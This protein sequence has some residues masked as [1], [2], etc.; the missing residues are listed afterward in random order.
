MAAIA[1]ATTTSFAHDV[2]ERSRTTPV[3]VDFWAPWCGPCH[4]LSP[5]LERAA[6]RYEGEVAVVKVNVDEEPQLAT[7]YRVQ[8]I[9]AVKGFVHGEI[10]REFTGVQ[11]E[12][13]IDQFFA[14]LRPSKADQLV[15]EAQASTEPEPLL[16]AALDM[17]AG[18]AGAIVALAT[19]LLDRGDF[20]EAGTLL[21]R[22]PGD[23]AVAQLRARLTLAQARTD[24]DGLAELRAAAAEGDSSAHLALGKALAAEGAHEEAIEALLAALGDPEVR[25]A[26]RQALLEV[27]DLL[28]SDS[29]VVRSARPRLASALYA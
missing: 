24:A 5:L 19:L 1:S 27:F 6:Q 9:P 2:I 23:P 25:D 22:V 4:Q 20:D 26:A 13:A 14:S 10:A 29:P 17:E 28:G 12:A 11:P 3:V 18:H 15:T 21:A 7:S 16:R 8:G